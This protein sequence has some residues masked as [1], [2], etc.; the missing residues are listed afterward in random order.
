MDTLADNHAMISAARKA[1]FT[2][3]GVL[4][5]A[6]WTLGTFQDLVQFGRLADNA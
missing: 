3:E 5:E 6:A 4:R 1:G 2:Q